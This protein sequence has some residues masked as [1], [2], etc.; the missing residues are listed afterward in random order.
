MLESFVQAHQEKFTENTTFMMDQSE[1]N[2]L[3][4]VVA[5]SDQEINE[6]NKLLELKKVDFAA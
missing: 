4:S 2:G 3:K 1:I 6:K 5:S